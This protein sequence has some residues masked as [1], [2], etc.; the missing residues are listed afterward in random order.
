MKDLVEMFTA[1]WA[2]ARQSNNTHTGIRSA[3]IEVIDA[4]DKDIAEFS[5][6]I[7]VVQK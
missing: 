4:S 3:T 6:D 5:W 7:A 2:R 1:H